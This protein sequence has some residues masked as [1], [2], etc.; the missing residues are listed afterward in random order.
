MN[1]FIY[2]VVTSL[3]CFFISMFFV[4]QLIERKK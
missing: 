2:T 4:G 3:F 1:K